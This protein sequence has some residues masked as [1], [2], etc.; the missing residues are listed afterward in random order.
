MKPA[1][2]LEAKLVLVYIQEI[3]RAFILIKVI[4]YKGLNWVT[5]DLLRIFFNCER[6]HD[7]I[8]HIPSAFPDSWNKRQVFYQIESASLCYH[9]K[10]ELVAGRS[11]I[12]LL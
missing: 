4:I 11:T 9:M 8:N 10:M 1:C 3:L 2:N 5:C 7:W 12:I 6:S